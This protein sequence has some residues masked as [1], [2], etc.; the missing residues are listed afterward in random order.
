MHVLDIAYAN[1]SDLSPR[2]RDRVGTV[3]EIEMPKTDQSA[4]SDGRLT[5]NCNCTALRKASRRVSQ[6]YDEALAASGLR[7][8][9]L[10]ILNQIQRMGTP[11]MGELARAMVMD[12][13]ALAHNVKPLERDGLIE[14]VA[15]PADQ[16]NRRITLTRA[17]QRK[18]AESE[19]SWARAQQRFEVSFGAKRAAALRQALAFIASDGFLEA[20]EGR[21]R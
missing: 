15:D 8:T 9:Q 2:A 1:I 6:L 3:P 4:P 19:R 7:V 13:G 17:G 14:T 5:S 21:A 18:I 10:A 11:A 16:R 20:F 12:R